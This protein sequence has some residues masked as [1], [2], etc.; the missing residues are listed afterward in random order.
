MEKLKLDKALEELRK[1]K[2]RKFDQTID[3]IVN[4]RGVDIRK[5]NVSL[6]IDVPH[7][8]RDKKVCGFLMGKNDLVKTITKPEFKKY[9]DKAAL[10]HLVEE[11][12]FFIAHASLMPAVATT[13]GKALGPAG[14]MPS[15][16]LG[17]ITKEDADAIKPLLEKISKSVKIRAKEASL[18]IPVGKASMK[19]ED[20]I[21][22]IKVIYKAI[23]NALPTKKE[24]VKN[25][26]V[27]MTMSKP[28]GVEL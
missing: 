18:K 7:K 14:K 15:P 27:K 17:I 1:S 12:D 11:Y 13:F 8:V 20:I 5:T 28:V 2:E 22:N 21:D 10:R 25:V 3:L 23:E 9:A 26:L 19:D 16:Q 4:L 6:V 24:N